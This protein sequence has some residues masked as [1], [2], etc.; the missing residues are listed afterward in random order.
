M[1]WIASRCLGFRFLI[2]MDGSAGRS[3]QKEV[4]PPALSLALW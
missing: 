1:S 3:D 2:S 4:W